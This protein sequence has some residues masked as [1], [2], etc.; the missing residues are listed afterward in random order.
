MSWFYLGSHEDPRHAGEKPELKDKITVP[1]LL[2]QSHS[3]PLCMTFYNAN[4][5]PSEYRHQAFVALHGSWN[6]SRRTGY[7]VIRAPAEQGAPTGEYIVGVL[8]QTRIPVWIVIFRIS[9]AENRITRKAVFF[10]AD[11]QITKNGRRKALLPGLKNVPQPAK[12]D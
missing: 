9:I 1:D 8:I 5:F 6:R 11:S 3:A 4:A 12:A 2:L 10:E 7:K